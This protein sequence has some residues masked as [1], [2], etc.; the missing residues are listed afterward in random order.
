MVVNKTRMRLRDFTCSGSAKSSRRRS[1]SG[2]PEGTKPNTAST[3][4]GPAS[5]VV[6]ILGTNHRR[7]RVR[8]NVSLAGWGCPLGDSASPVGGWRGPALSTR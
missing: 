2:S 5:L 7:R 1:W 3:T 8:A 4:L 6:F